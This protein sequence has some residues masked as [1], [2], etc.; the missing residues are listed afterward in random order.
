MIVT[1]NGSKYEN[2]QHMKEIHDRRDQE[3]KVMLKKSSSKIETLT[4]DEKT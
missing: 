4:F 1:M 2:W 3:N